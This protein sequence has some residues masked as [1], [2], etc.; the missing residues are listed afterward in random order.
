[1]AE[2]LLRRFNRFKYIGLERRGGIIK[3]GER[4]VRLARFKFFG[5]RN[6]KFGF[7]DTD[8]ADDS[9]TQADVIFLGSIFTHTTFEEMSR[10]LHLFYGRVKDECLIIFSF[11]ESETTRYE[12]AK[13]YGFKDVFHKSFFDFKA[14]EKLISEIGFVFS[15]EDYFTTRKRDRHSIAVIKKVGIDRRDLV[16]PE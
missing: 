7:L 15:I 16:F 11:F 12:G 2:F 3:Y 8:F 5:I 9:L 10:V 6:C 1:M 14:V 4:E 13:Y